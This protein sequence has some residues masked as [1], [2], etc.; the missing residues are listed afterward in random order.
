MFAQ[1]LSRARA[2]SIATCTSLFST[3]VQ[4]S[5]LVKVAA[6]SSQRFFE[7][8][9][10]TTG[11]NAFFFRWPRRWTY[12]FL[13]TAWCI[14]RGGPPPPRPPLAGA[15][16]PRPRAGGAPRCC[17][18]CAT[19]APR[20]PTR[21]TGGSPAASRSLSC[22]RRRASPASLYLQ[23]SISLAKGPLYRPFTPR[24]GN[25]G[26]HL[27]SCTCRGQR[28]ESVQGEPAVGRSR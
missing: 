23:S 22:L 17:P 13:S 8:V 27:R 28:R 7:N 15:G 9:K 18:R 12:R 4:R 5:E 19:A 26:L 25:C 1:P 10:T 3:D 2:F 6:F 11:S 14:V 16:A 21:C 24:P 20:A